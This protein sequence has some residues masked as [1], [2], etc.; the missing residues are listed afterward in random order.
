[1]AACTRAQ[2]ETGGSTMNLGKKEIITDMMQTEKNLA[3]AYC[4]AELE[5]S[6]QS[7]RTALGDLQRKIQGNHASLF[8]EMH[9]RGWYKTP[10]AG[11]QAIESTIISWEQKFQ[12]EPEL[13]PNA[14]H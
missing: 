3:S 5:A 6:N 12:K 4:R 14:K 2:W 13:S 11:Q 8:H 7:I 9:Q 10:T 1:M